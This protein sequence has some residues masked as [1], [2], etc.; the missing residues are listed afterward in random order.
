[1]RLFILSFFSL[2]V[3]LLKT[4]V[5]I[6]LQDSRRAPIR[7]ALLFFFLRVRLTDAYTSQNDGPTTA[8]SKISC[9]PWTD[10]KLPTTGSSISFCVLHQR[11]NGC[12]SIHVTW[13]RI[14]DVHG[15]RV[16]TRTF[17]RDSSQSPKFRNVPGQ[18]KAIDMRLYLPVTG[19]SSV[20]SE[21]TVPH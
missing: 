2:P 15:L 13:I 3:F 1:M 11:R 12:K 16:I 10:Y 19:E 21:R 8:R 20:P 6:A 7:W 18:A 9:R 5:R 14:K 4:W 17:I